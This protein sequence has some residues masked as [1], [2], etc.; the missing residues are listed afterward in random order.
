MD[1]RQ[2]HEQYK[3]D[4]NALLNEVLPMVTDTFD[5]YRL[6]YDRQEAEG[7]DPESLRALAQVTT[8][9]AVAVHD[10]EVQYAETFINLLAS[11]SRFGQQARAQQAQ[12]QMRPRLERSKA[13]VET[14]QKRLDE[15]GGY[16]QAT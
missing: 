1:R 13:A 5:S 12:A 14:W 6:E 3:Q 16:R 11:R 15:L 8:G 9:A 4:V 10:T 2:A 7:A